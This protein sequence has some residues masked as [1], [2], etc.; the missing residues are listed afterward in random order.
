MDH[1]RA[2]EQESEN[3]TRRP[4][5]RSKLQIKRNNSFTKPQTRIF[6]LLLN[7]RELKPFL[8]NFPV[9]RG[10]FASTEFPLESL[11]VK[12]LQFRNKT[13]LLLR[14]RWHSEQRPKTEEQPF[15]VE[16]TAE[17][18][19]KTGRKANVALDLCVSQRYGR[20]G[21]IKKYNIGISL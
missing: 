1:C 7:S 11:W 5:V 3:Y 12:H 15:C 16:N 18:V 8:W 17:L 21:S 6:F 14:R 9:C 10:K 4:S 19:G 2:W 20:S 13:A